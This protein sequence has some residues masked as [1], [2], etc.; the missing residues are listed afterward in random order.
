MCTQD[1]LNSFTYVD[2]KTCHPSRNIKKI[3]E[4]FDLRLRSTWDSDEKYEKNQVNIKIIS[5][6]GITPHH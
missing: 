2:P 1:S 4:S 6:L 5:F 3:P